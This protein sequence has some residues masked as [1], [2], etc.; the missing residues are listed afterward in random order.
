MAAPKSLVGGRIAIHAAIRR[1][2][3]QG[4]N[5]Q[6][7]RVTGR[8][9]LPL[10]AVV[11]TARLDGC[12]RVLSGGFASFAERADPGMV[13]VVDRFGLEDRDAYRMYSDPYGDYSEGRF[14]WLLSEIRRVEPPIE[15]TGRQGI[16]K[17]PIQVE[18]RVA[19]LSAGA[20]LP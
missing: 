10:G 15:A 9:E 14:V 12:V 8:M 2:R 19:A 7:R 1:P 13:W 16:W 20:P 17:L 3:R 11:A 4:W 18:T 5:G 6:V